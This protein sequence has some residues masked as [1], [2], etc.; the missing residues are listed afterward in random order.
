[1]DFK[2]VR[3]IICI[4]LALIL[5]TSCGKKDEENQEDISSNTSSETSSTVDDGKDYTELEKEINTLLD[6]KSYITLS[7][8]SISTSPKDASKI[9]F[10]IKII[11]DDIEGN[12]LDVLSIFEPNL[13]LIDFDN[14][15]I[16]SQTDE[17]LY[18]NSWVNFPTK[19]GETTQ[20]SPNEPVKVPT[21]NTSM[22]LPEGK[23]T[24]W[25]LILLNH[26]EEN[27][28]TSEINFQQVKFDT[29]YV[30]SRAAQ[31]YKDMCADALKEGITL[32]LRSGYRSMQTQQVNYNANIER[33][34]NQGLSKE[35][36]TVQT[37]LY[38]T[39]PGHSEH[40]TGLAFDIIT[41]EYHSDIYTLD[42]RFAETDAYAWLLENC[43]DYGFI[44]RYE[45]H[46]TDIT[47]I[48]FEPWHYR[49]VGVE[50]AKYIEANDICFEEYIELLKANGR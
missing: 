43:A 8:V 22:E 41:P 48:N 17:I 35:E 29:Q 23:L 28:I 13:D 27:K 30:D 21:V 42:E 19:N 50:H 33:L 47:Q 44:L 25:N 34:Q 16:K 1:M 49:Y 32:Y 31:Q 45:A 38:Y 39:V 40:H 26:G 12:L 24:D 6:G 11:G 15:V 2:I 20:V 5:L 46:K 4:S 18:P 3:I 7:A 14:S 9:V 10:D 36:A 37:N